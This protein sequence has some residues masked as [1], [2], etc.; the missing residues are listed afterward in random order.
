[1]TTH[2]QME[3]RAMMKAT[4]WETTPLLTYRWDDASMPSLG[5]GMNAWT[6]I[7]FYAIENSDIHHP[8]AQSQMW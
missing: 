4:Q 3:K 1:M 8:T 7:A 5:R 2:Q 6:I